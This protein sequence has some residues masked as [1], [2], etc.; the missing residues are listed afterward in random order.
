VQLDQV[1]YLTVN[2]HIQIVLSRLRNCHVRVS[3]YGFESVRI[4]GAYHAR[5]T[6]QYRKLL[7]ELFLTNRPP[8]A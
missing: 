5:Y 4:V 8:K 1:E 2:F 7:R 6:F 3:Q